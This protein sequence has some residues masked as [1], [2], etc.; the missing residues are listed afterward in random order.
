MS[1]F[2]IC[3]GGRRAAFGA[4]LKAQSE[5]AS[6]E[7]FWAL[8]AQINTMLFAE[9]PCESED[10]PR[11]FWMM[12]ERPLN[13]EAPAPIKGGRCFSFGYDAPKE[14]SFD[15]HGY[16]CACRVCRLTS[17]GTN[18]F[19]EDQAEELMQILESSPWKTAPRYG[20]DKIAY[21]THLRAKWRADQC[22]ALIRALPSVIAGARTLE[23][24]L[25]GLHGLIEQIKPKT[26]LDPRFTIRL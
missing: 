26:D 15:L 6:D 23:A 17:L 5:A 25:D 11:R 8:D 14:S 20:Q 3:G 24:M 22:E 9:S 13:H 2:E 16:D 18:G 10:W 1:G 4:L 12:G 21:A 19:A 7:E